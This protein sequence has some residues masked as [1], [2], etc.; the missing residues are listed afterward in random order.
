MGKPTV[1]YRPIAGHGRINAIVL[2]RTGLATCAISDAE[3]L[4]AVRS[5]TPPH[6][7][8][9]VFAGARAIDVIATLW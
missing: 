3:L 5:A 6:A 1:V 8:A 2:E 4:D 9:E 7:A